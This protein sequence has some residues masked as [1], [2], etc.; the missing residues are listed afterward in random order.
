MGYSYSNATSK[1]IKAWENERIERNRQVVERKNEERMKLADKIAMVLV[2]R[3][4]QVVVRPGPDP[5]EREC[6]DMAKEIRDLSPE[7]AV[8]V[9]KVL[10]VN[11]DEG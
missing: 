6:Y 10:K 3:I 8:L 7:L 1:E 5:E 11:E 4:N 9:A 2:D